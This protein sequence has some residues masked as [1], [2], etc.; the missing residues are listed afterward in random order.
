MTGPPPRA[1]AR[2]W[3]HRRLRTKTLAVLAIALV[4]LAVSVG[5]VLA[6]AR[7]ERAAQDQVLRALDVNAQIAAT[8]TLMNDAEGAVN[9]F[10]LTREPAA[11]DTI[12]EVG[13]AWTPALQRLAGLIRDTP[14]L[15]ER[16]RAMRALSNERPIASLLE[17]AHAHPSSPV[18]P[19]E[20]LD[21]S[22]AALDGL[23]RELAGMREAQDGL[24]AGHLADA[25]RAE[26]AL[27]AAAV[28]GAG[29][30]LVGGVVAVVAFAAGVT[31]RIDL[32]RANAE[33]LA[34]GADL[35]PS[36]DADDEVG[37]LARS[38]GEAAAL[39]CARD[40]E[41]AQRMRELT[42]VN[43]ELE[44]FT[45]SVSHDLRA[46]LRH[47]TGFAELLDRSAGP[48]LDND[49][50]RRLRV[51]VDAATRMGRLIDDLLAFSRVGRT[52]VARER[53][54]LDDLVRE[55]RRE[56]AVD[57]QS[58]RVDWRI[59][60]LPVVEGDP[61]LLRLVLI[62]LIGNALKYS[63]ERPDPRIEIG[64]NGHAHGEAV[65][66]VRD[67]GVG[68]DM[69]YAGRL[70]GVFQRLH[71]ADRFEGTGIGLANVRRIVH[72]HG[73][74]TWAEGEVD[75]GA[76]FYVALPAAPGGPAT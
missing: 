3:R 48:K 5:L 12:A 74:R 9:R 11:M 19:A 69:Q 61:A 23:R 76:T 20:L 67:N 38:I 25:R 40:A 1:P 73:G 35:V 30:G 24:L 26:T 54:A 16:A 71:G 51:V 43:D 31:R 66:F 41:L 14:A 68:F 70:F 13:A 50:R 37:V 21:R 45:Y 29:L 72:R 22:H 64:A 46:P 49:E 33:R 52:S 7:R 42:S 18:P 6:M 15:V 57:P 58:A 55:A 8:I 36:D 44:A 27:V 59:Q 53:V 63:R 32:A 75:R 65:V 34:H 17:H 47:I 2:W 39:L 10:L 62:N 4:P 60:P 56:L 28:A